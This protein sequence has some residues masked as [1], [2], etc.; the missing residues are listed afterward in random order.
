[1]RVGAELAAKFW[2]YAFRHYLRMYNLIPHAGME[3]EL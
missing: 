3:N 2:T 1:M